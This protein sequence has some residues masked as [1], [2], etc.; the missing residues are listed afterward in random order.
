MQAKRR[1]RY[2]F[3]NDTYV[4]LV[5]LHILMGVFINLIPQFSTVY[6]S[7]VCAFFVLKIIVTG[8]H[9]KLI[10]VLFGASYFVAAESLF[11]MTGGGLFYEFS[12]Y[13]VILLMLMGMFFDGLSGKGYP[14]FIYLI[15][16]VPSILVA[17]TT[18]GYDLNFRTSIAFVLSGPVCLGV[19]A[20][21]C[22]GKKVSMQVLLQ[23]VACMSYPIITMATH[24][25]LYN[26][27]VK[28]V[29]TS[30]GSNYA[31]SGGFG[32]NQVSTLLGLGMFALTVRFFM[33]SPSLFL[34]LFNLVLLAA[35][36]FRALVTLSRGGVL[37]AVL[38][39]GAF[40]VIYFGRSKYQQ[41]QQIIVS[42]LLLLFVSL[43][44]WVI[45]L[46]QS[47]GLVGNR[48]S[49]ED[50]LG[51]EKKDVST[52]R[53]DLFV[54]EFAGFKEHP[55]L[56]VGANGMKQ[57]RLED[58]G[59]IT[60]SHNE[61]SRLLSEH[62]IFGVLILIIL[63]FKPLDFRSRNRNNIFFYSFLAFWFATINH[64]AMRIAAPAFI[65]AL[66]LLNVTH[67]KPPLPRKQFKPR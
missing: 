24:L 64:S 22:Y 59:K 2:R 53:V 62:G 20:L 15:L 30:T 27:S 29:L 37:A 18:L 9:E 32:P 46:N 5:V 54:D 23:I 63:I 36:S 8:K 60:A 12:K 17:S 61:I 67:E 47:S 19:S 10:W 7:L 51:R 49:N 52:G 16:L 13:F 50:A 57:E 3:T 25:F 41:K 66:A 40:L 35:V 4:A 48:Y 39:I 28:E 26:P 38:V 43:L 65:Y 1:K 42:V 14:Y 56:G 31:T 21:Y 33:K 11:R 34:K 44:T 58:T 6:F 55:F 45:S